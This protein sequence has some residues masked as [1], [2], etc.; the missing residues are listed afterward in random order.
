[1]WG[2]GEGGKGGGGWVLLMEG[3]E[4]GRG[5]RGRFW[6]EGGKGGKNGIYEGDIAR[7]SP[8][9]FHILPTLPSSLPLCCSSGYCTACIKYPFSNPNSR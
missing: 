2:E 6:L 8:Y 7:A 9:P 1:M 3:A 4:G 5:E